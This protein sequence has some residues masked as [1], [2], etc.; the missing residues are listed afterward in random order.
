M[1]AFSIDL[2]RPGTAGD[3]ILRRASSSIPIGSEPI[4]W[5]LPIIRISIGTPSVAFNS[6]NREIASEI[7]LELNGQSRDCLE[8]FA[9]IYGS[10]IA[11]NQIDVRFKGFVGFRFRF[12]GKPRATVSEKIRKEIPQP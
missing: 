7:S 10:L 2:M 9:V 5:F 4:V 11:T 12:R 1:R 3:P 6:P 8:R